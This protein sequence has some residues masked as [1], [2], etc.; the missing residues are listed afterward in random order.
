[1][2]NVMMWGHI[3]GRGND[4]KLYPVLASWGQVLQM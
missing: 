2:N 3:T 4:A 1:M